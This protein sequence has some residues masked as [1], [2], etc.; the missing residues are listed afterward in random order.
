M[1]RYWKP[2]LIMLG[3]LSL[4]VLIIYYSW[5]WP[6]FYDCLFTNTITM[7]IN[8]AIAYYVGYKRDKLGRVR[9]GGVIPPKMIWPVIALIL[10]LIA[11]CV[12]T[13]IEY[14][15]IVYRIAESVKDKLGIDLETLLNM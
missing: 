11:I 6:L 9:L 13:L 3:I 5:A 4:L 1:K 10:T 2:F 15:G 14:F 12:S 7:G 8:A